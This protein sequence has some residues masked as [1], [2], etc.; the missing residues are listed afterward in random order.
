MALS[1]AEL[2]ILEFT[3]DGDFDPKLLKHETRHFGQRFILTGKESYFWAVTVALLCERYDHVDIESVYYAYNRAAQENLEILRGK[4]QAKF[5]S[6]DDELSD[7]EIFQ[8]LFKSFLL[9]LDCHDLSLE[10][11]ISQT[12]LAFE[13]LLHKGLIEDPIEIAAGTIAIAV[14]GFIPF[15]FTT[16]TRRGRVVYRKVSATY[17]TYE[18][19]RVRN[20]DVRQFSIR[21]IKV[22]SAFK[23][24]LIEASQDNIDDVEK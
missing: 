4:Y 7:K 19:K 20:E 24:A 21:L 22:L 12:Q 18:R 14:L 11:V 9:N 1:S 2:A 3:N 5:L 17:W 10:E 23:T 16:K 6:F 13:S 15:G 8:K